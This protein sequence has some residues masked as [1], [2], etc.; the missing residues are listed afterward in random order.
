VQNLGL[1][2]IITMPSS[3]QLAEV[4]SHAG[5]S[6]TELHQCGVARKVRIFMHDIS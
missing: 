4:Q 6:G 3:S 1:I 5:G 2:A